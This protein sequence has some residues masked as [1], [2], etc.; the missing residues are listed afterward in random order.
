[1]KNDYYDGTKLLSLKDIEGNKPEIYIC[2]SNRTAGKTTYWNRMLVNRFKRNYEKFCLLYRYTYEVD[3]CADKFFKDI[4]DLFF[5]DDTMESEKGGNGFYRKLYLN[6]I[7]CGYA[8]A[9]NQS[10]QVK[11][12]SHFFKDVSSILFDEFQDENN[13]YLSGE[14]RKFRSI[15]TSIARGNGKHVRYVPVYMVSNPV[16]LIN[17]YYTAMNISGR[18][19]GDTKFLRGRGWVLE[20]GYL[21]SADKAQ[22][23]SGFNKAFT[24]DDGYLAYSAMGVYLNDNKTFIEK[25]DGKFKYLATISYKGRDYAVKEY[26]ESGI[27]YCDTKVDYQYP[28][29]ISATLNDHQMNYVMLKK[30]DAFINLLRYYFTHGAFRF[31]DLSCKDCIITLISL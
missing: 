18:L 16:S 21:E 15:H 14:V 25:V 20:Q 17:P 29:R 4:H 13:E 22:R 1:M 23:E 19:K 31:H 7:E 28:Y 3:D 24:D 2:T 6:G 27:I 10:V 8:V 9:L 12:Y 26:T 5:P 11:K 30:N